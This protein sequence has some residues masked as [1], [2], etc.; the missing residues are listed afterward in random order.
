MTSFDCDSL[1]PDNYT[2]T[3]ALD[4]D[5]GKLCQPSGVVQRSFL[6]KLLPEKGF[7]RICPQN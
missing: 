1:K 6:L 4:V 7:G 3:K 5:I 2:M